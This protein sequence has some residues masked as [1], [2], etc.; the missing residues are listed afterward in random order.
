MPPKNGSCAALSVVT[1]QVDA[2]IR[3]GRAVIPRNRFRIEAAE[4]RIMRR[5][6]RRHLAGRSGEQRVETARADAEQGVVRKTQLGLRNQWKINQPFDR[7]VVRRANVR[8][9]HAFLLDGVV[10]RNV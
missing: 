3:G 4:E 2:Q 1:W 10:E 9:E 8:D 7:G 6:E 5:V